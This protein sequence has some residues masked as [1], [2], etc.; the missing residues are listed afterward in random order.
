MDEFPTIVRLGDDA[1]LVTFAPTISWGVGVRVRSAA[2]RLRDMQFDSV[3]DVVP[4]YTTLAVY[5]DS[6]RVSFESMIASVAPVI[7]MA[8]LQQQD[9]SALVEIP[10]SYN[11]P[12]LAEVAERTGLTVEDVIDRHSSRVYRAYM[13]GFAPGFAYLGDLDESLV[14]PRRT[15]P[16]MRVPPG[17]VAIAGAQ[18]AVY[19]LQTPGGWHLIGT[20][21]TVMFDA[22]R[23]PPALVHAGN[24]VRFVKVDL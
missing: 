18:T 19:P 21:S 15:V 5:F 16:R 3:T 12:D 8:D 2:G 10:V 22:E 24:T 11:G 17:S 1:L 6:V 9:I 14:L 7:N 20:T 23:D 4:G 13:S